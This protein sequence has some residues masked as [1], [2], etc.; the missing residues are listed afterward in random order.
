[1]DPLTGKRREALAKGTSTH[2]DGEEE[3]GKDRIYVRRDIE[4][5]VEIVERREVEV[6]RMGDM[7]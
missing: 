2:W 4:T 1:M 3:V 7:F 5:E 6:V